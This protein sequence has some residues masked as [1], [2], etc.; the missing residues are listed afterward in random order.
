[1]FALIAAYGAATAFFGPAF[2]AFVPEVVAKDLLA[3]ANAVDQFVRPCALR[4]IGP[5]LAGFVIA[6]GGSAAAF[7]FDAGTF[8]VSMLCFVGVRPG[9][10]HDADIDGEDENASVFGDV[11]EGFRYVRGNVWL[12]GTFLAA[13]FA[14]LL[15]MGPLEVLLPYIVKN[16]LHAG[17]G[18]LGTI[19]ACG[20]VGALLSAL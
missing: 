20:G 16:E 17:A 19:L 2:D 8:A 10:V 1:M 15:I 13:T 11:K 5:A 12:W 6:A 4:P 14:Y 7:G 18:T 3:Q 9:S